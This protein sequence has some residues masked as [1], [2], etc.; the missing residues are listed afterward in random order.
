MDPRYTEEC[1]RQLEGS[2]LQK[3][4]VREVEPR[5]RPYARVLK[6]T[7]QAIRGP[8]GG[9]GLHDEHLTG[10]HAMQQS[11]GES[12]ATHPP[13]VDETI[14]KFESFKTFIT[15]TPSREQEPMRK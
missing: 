14:V 12:V 2:L 3:A 10:L 11:I 4:N 9:S 7:Q 15:W 5:I 1:T 13:G 8:N 6:E